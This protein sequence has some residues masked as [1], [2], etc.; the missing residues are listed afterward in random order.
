MRVFQYLEI[1][2]YGISSSRSCDF[3]RA[4]ENVDSEELGTVRTRYDRHWEN[5]FPE[6][7]QSESR[8]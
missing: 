6:D 2:Y 1:V 7:I 4:S 8:D 5:G 3:N